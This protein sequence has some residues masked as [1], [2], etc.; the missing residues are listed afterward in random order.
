MNPQTVIRNVLVS[1]SHW[2]SCRQKLR[3]LTKKYEDL[4]DRKS[5]TKDDLVRLKKD[6]EKAKVELVSAAEKHEK[7]V[8]EFT[9]VKTALGESRINRR[10]K[11]INLKGLAKSVGVLAE[12]FEKALD[13]QPAQEVAKWRPPAQVIDVEVIDATPKKT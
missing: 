8:I 6:M 2:A 4:Q 9:Q 11:P 1:A 10:K 7:A 5:T 3:D 12:A 13:P